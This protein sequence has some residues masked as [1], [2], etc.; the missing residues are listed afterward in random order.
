MPTGVTWMLDQGKHDDLRKCY[1]LFE[2]N[3]NTSVKHIITKFTP[4]LMAKGK[5]ITENSELMKQANSEEFI[6][7]LTELKEEIDELVKLA[8]NNHY[9]IQKAMS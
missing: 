2:L 9:E 1:D 8:F 5:N 7:K 4:W 6:R 3:G